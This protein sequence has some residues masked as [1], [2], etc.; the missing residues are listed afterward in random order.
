MAKFGMIGSAGRM[1]QAIEAELAATGATLAG[2]IDIGDDP[3]LLARVSDVLIDFSSPKA[4]VSNLGAAVAAGVPIVVGTTGLTED[5][6][7]TIDDA[8]HHIAVLQTGNTSLGVTVLAAIVR[9]AAARLGPDWDIEILEMHHRH[10]ADAPSGTAKLLGEAAAAGRGIALAPHTDN[11]R[12][13]KRNVGDIGF[14]SLRGGSVFGDHTIIFATDGERIEM[15][16]R[17]ETR[18]IFAR[19]AIKAAAWLIGKPAGR[20][21]MDQVLG[22]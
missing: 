21:T 17:A 2:A 7:Q 18:Q 1:G 14:A 16:H 20:Y 4:L 15:S 11:D 12:D 13:H 5:H 8:A 6:H 19:G 3:M 10:K 22:L 9:Q